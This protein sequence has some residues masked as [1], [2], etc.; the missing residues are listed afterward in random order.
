[1][2]V[3]SQAGF[4]WA[5]MRLAA[6]IAEE[7]PEGTALSSRSGWMSATCPICLADGSTRLDWA[8]LSRPVRERNRRPSVN[9]QARGEYRALIFLDFDQGWK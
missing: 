1:M 6:P 9:R 7:Q 8:S 3:R 2:R 5:E 4:A